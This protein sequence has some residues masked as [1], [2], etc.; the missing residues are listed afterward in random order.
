MFVFGKTAFVL[1]LSRLSEKSGALEHLSSGAISPASSSWL[2]ARL[3]P[4][5][6]GNLPVASNVVVFV[7]QLLTATMIKSIKSSESFINGQTKSWVTP[8]ENVLVPKFRDR[9][10]SKAKSTKIQA[11]RGSE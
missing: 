8:L 7:R 2:G 3:S 6:M 5:G 1:D 10:F 11:G 4:C 9:T